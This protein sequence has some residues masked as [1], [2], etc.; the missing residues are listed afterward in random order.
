[1]SLNVIGAIAF[2]GGA[3]LTTL[4]VL[5]H[6]PDPHAILHGAQSIEASRI[7]DVALCG[8]PLGIGFVFAVFAALAGE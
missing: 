5:S 3:I 1:M 8:A 7:G 2:I 4:C 6:Y